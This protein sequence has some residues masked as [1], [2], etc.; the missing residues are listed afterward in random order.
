MFPECDISLLFHDTYKGKECKYLIRTISKIYK[1]DFIVINLI[2]LN[3]LKHVCFST[4][5]RLPFVVNI[6][7]D[8]DVAVNTNQLLDDW[9][10]GPLKMT[11]L[12]NKIVLNGF[13]LFLN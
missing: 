1:L 12:K 13:V 6:V 4:G 8:R 5:S 3:F 7:Y 9:K 2:L 11:V 10:K